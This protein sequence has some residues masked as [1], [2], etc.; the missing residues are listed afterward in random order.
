M[1]NDSRRSFIKKSAAVSAGA[2][3]VST[4]PNVFASIEKALSIPAIASMA[5]SKM[6]SMLLF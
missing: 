3:T 6:L 4:S 2:A 1:V 5:V